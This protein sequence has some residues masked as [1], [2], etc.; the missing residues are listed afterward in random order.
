[1]VSTHKQAAVGR[2]RFAPLQSLDVCVLSGAVPMG[3]AVCTPEV[4]RG[5][6]LLR[7]L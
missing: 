5:P 7:I 4:S 3:Q 6:F 2:D 1:M